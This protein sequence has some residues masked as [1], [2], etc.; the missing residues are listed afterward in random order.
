MIIS[1]AMRETVDLIEKW[2]CQ[3]AENSKVIRNYLKSNKTGREI[4]RSTYQYFVNTCQLEPIES[5][6]TADKARI[7]KT[8]KGWAA[9][10]KKE[11]ISLAK[12]IYLFENLL[13][14]QIQ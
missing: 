2:V 1:S 11:L 8:A 10:E 14:R 12:T 6:Q 5:L 9:L 3:F 7:W 4:G 13:Q